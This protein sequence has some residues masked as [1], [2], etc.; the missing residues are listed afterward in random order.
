MSGT[1]M[2]CPVFSSV[3]GYWV[4]VV[5]ELAFG[6]SAAEP[7]ESHVHCLGAS[8]LDVVGDHIVCC[9]VV[10]LD[11]CG[12]LLVA[13]F[14]EQQLHGDCFL[15]ID[16]EGSYFV[17]GCAGHDGLENFGYVENGDIVRW[18]LNVG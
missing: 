3:V 17:F 7:V 6:I 12:Q 2:F 10:G 16:V 4:P 5:S 11:G 15:G 13:H 9:A 8:W 18:V 1:M 14:F